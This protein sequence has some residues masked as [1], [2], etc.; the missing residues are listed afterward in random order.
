VGESGTIVSTT[1]GGTT[2]RSQTSGT[3]NYLYG[4]ACPSSS[5]CF[6]VGSRGTILRTTNGARV[7]T[8]S[9]PPGTGPSPD[10]SGGGSSGSG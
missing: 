2:W 6:A 8:L 3:T 4:L 10:G 1:D 5:T 7:S 9:I